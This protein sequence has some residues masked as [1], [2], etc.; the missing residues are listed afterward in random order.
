MFGFYKYLKD[1]LSAKCYEHLMSSKLLKYIPVTCTTSSIVQGATY[2]RKMSY[3]PL[4]ANSYPFQVPFVELY[5]CTGTKYKD[6]CEVRCDE[7]FNKTVSN[8]QCGSDGQWKNLT[9]GKYV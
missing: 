2:H 5:S 3:Y 6:T 7:G 4:R 9:G 1:I 8:V